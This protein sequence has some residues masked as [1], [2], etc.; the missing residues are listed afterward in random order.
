MAEPEHDIHFRLCSFCEACCGLRIEVDSKSR[1]VISIKGDIDNPLSRGFIC[2]KSQAYR[3]LE[4][5]AERL[6]VPMIRKN[7]EFVEASWDEALDLAASR[8][9]EIRE[10]DGQNA[11]GYYIGN[12]VAHNDGLMLYGGLMAQMLPTKQSFTAGSSD[13]ITKV[14][15]SC[16]MFGS[17]AS[18][19]VPDIDRTSTL[20]IIGANPVVSNGSLVTAPGWPKRLKALRARGG[21]VITIDPRRT[22]TAMV[23]DEYVAIAPGTDAAFL[24]AITHTLFEEGLVK[25]GR[26]TDHIAGLSTLEQTAAAFSPEVCADWTGIPAETTRRIA[27]SLANDGPAVVYGRLG[28]CAQQFGSLSS[29]LIDVINILTGNLDEPGGAMFPLPAVPSLIY[30]QKIVDGV[31]PVGRWHS[32]VTGMPELSGFLPAATLADEIATPGTDQIRTLVTFCGNP[33]RSVAGSEQLDS[34]LAD[35]EFMV[36]LDFYINET[37]RHA[38]VIL[39]PCAHLEQTHCPVFSMPFMVRNYVKWDEATFAPDADAMPDWRIALELTSRILA[40]TVEAIERGAISALVDQFAPAF[41]EL[42]AR[43]DGIVEELLCLPGPTKFVD[44]FLRTGPYGDQFGGKP[45]G[46]TL[47]RLRA[48]PHGV[49]FGALE[50]RLPDLLLTPSGKI[51]IAPDRLVADV[52]RLRTAMAAPDQRLQLIGRR[53]LRSNNSWMHNLPSLAKGPDRTALAIHPADAMR[54]GIKDGGRVRLTSDTGFV[55]AT[56]QLDADIMEG[57]VSLPHGFD[58]RRNGVRMTHARSVGGANFNALTSS[59]QFDRPSGNAVLS[60]IPV[61][62]VAENV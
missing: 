33:V 49:D 1:S 54:W 34:A 24:F 27:R 62:L 22:E 26:L 20:L 25:T 56:A 6:T 2:P 45:D 21:R 36:A 7:G 12:P 9:R 15:S 30:N 29:W 10:R 31:P 51:E 57:V 19:P 60:G 52:A 13:H 32:R 8:I 48:Q 3:F 28:T 23:S 46:L 17:E 55:I 16:L 18:I 14:L 61:E 11:L 58:H 50:S 42:A 37:T 59:S 44:L 39:P 41:P 38:D 35:I 4:E 53:H 40:V 47:E 5:D 43:R